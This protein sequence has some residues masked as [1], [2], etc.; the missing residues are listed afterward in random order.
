MKTEAVNRS[1]GK[2][3]PFSMLVTENSLLNLYYSDD[4]SHYCDT[5]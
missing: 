3:F 5:M 1:V 2:V 4:I